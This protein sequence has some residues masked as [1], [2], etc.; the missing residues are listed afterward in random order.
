MPANPERTA[1]PPRPY[2]EVRV[3]E[4]HFTCTRAPVRFLSGLTTVAVS[5]ATWWFSTH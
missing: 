1:D 2:I 5:F 3:G 4:A